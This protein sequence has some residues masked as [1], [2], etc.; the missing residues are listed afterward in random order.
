MAAAATNV[1]SYAFLLAAMVTISRRYFVWAF[2]LKSL[3]KIAL[4]SGVMGAVVYPIGNSLTS[5]TLINLIAEICIGVV[6]YFLMLFLLR[7]PQKEEIRVLYNFR[8]RI[9]RGISR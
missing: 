3:G 6:V 1:T 7:E 9:L 5:S 4:S 8:R 2:P